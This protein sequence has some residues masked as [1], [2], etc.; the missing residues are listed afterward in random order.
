M[1]T[2]EEKIKDYLS[3]NKE[4]HDATMLLFEHLEILSY[5]TYHETVNFILN[6]KNIFFK[7]H[8]SGI[9]FFQK[10]IEKASSNFKNFDIFLD[11]CID[12]VAEFKRLNLTENELINNCY[13][14]KISIFY[15]FTKNFF[16]I[17]SIVE[18]S[19]IDNFIFINFLPEIRKYDQEYAD[20]RTKNL[21]ADQNNADIKNDLS[22]LQIVMN[23]PEEHIINRNLNYNP[24]YIHKLIR[25][26]EIDEF[27][28][29]LSHENI[30][31]NY[32]IPFSYYERAITVDKDLSLIKVAAI[33]G[34]LRI[35]KFLWMH[36][37]EIEPDLLRYAYFGKNYEIIHT[38]EETCS[39]DEVFN[40]SIVQGS[41]ELIE[42][43]F[44]KYKSEL[45]DEDNENYVIDDV[46][47][48]GHFY[49]LKCPNLIDAI[50]CS[51]YP[52]VAP[53]LLKIL[54]IAN[55]EE[56]TIV[57]LD[58]SILLS[59]IR[60]FNLFKFI[61]S[62]RDENVNKL[63]CNCFFDCLRTSLFFHYNDTFKFLF[64]YLKEN[65]NFTTF[66]R[67]GIEKNH[68]VANY[69]LDCQ[70]EEKD[71]NKPLIFQYMKDKIEFND[72][73]LAITFYSENIVVKMIKLYEPFKITG[74]IFDF[75]SKLKNN[76]SKKMMIS[77][78]NQ[79][80][81][82]LPRQLLLCF[83][84]LLNDYDCSLVADAIIQKLPP[85]A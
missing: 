73:K 67:Y 25:N 74:N 17:Q 9:S 50:I 26:D 16:S 35:F 61:L 48:D 1:N 6:Y 69:I 28:Y 64:E 70:F 34:S 56:Q 76:I 62:Q 11:I 20:L 3:Q 43:S 71:S 39:H 77:L 4:Y 58:K 80:S 14:F 36:L 47:D 40:E 13:E 33:Y 49:N 46:N 31:F 68:D 18:N 8:A 12:F 32:K 30:E 54:S 29:Y 55:K 5:D 57:P 84:A 85:K 22:F 27:Q 81:S 63:T 66:L 52:I 38:C 10:L 60:D 65:I 37:D 15:F 78:F 7:D 75:V 79:L 51:Y 44:E 82:F 2:K 83:S 41:H 72:F 53:N 24:S 21:L 23:N 19:F 45:I 42:Y 59:A